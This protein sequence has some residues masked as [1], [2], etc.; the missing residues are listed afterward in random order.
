L[1]RYD[2]IPPN[3]PDRAA[4]EKL[5]DAVAA[6]KD[7]VRSRLFW[8]TDLDRAKQV[9]Q[10]EGKPILYLRLLGRLD[11]ELSCANSRF[12]RTTLYPDPAVNK[13]LREKFVLVWES[14]RPVPVVTID[15]G[16]GRVLKRTVTGNSIHYVLDAQ[17]NPIDAL[18]GLYGVKPFVEYLARAASVAAEVSN[19]P[20]RREAILQTYHRDAIRGTDRAWAADV[21]RAQ[22]PA[23]LAAADADDAA[24]QKLAML[25]QGE[26]AFSP[27]VTQ[28][29]A[30]K[31]PPAQRAM[32]LARSKGFVET[33]LMR[34]I[35]Q[36]RTNVAQDTVRNEYTLH[37]R[38]H[39]WLGAN[40]AVALTPFNE[41]VYAEL[42]LTPRSDPW[43]GLAP[44]DGFAAVDESAVPASR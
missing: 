1:A 15:F 40:P 8:Y 26:A 31:A 28:A 43:L 30:A 33:P 13:L 20:S 24:W 5:I 11:Q 38:A 27:E 41:R 18:P 17:G 34:M 37:R 2:R 9:A 42:F 4:M 3:S 32:P 36:L 23:T 16:D 10:R 22:L 39:E 35:A 29:I 12:F 7:A 44:A 14:E 21:A 25:H 6:Q 19:D